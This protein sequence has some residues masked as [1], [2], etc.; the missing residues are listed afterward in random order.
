MDSVCGRFHLL[1]V[2]MVSH[3]SPPAP[4]M[5]SNCGEWV[6]IKT[7]SWA[8]SGR[9]KAGVRMHLILNKQNFS[10]TLNGSAQASPSRM[11]SS[12]LW[13]R[14]G[15]VPGGPTSGGAPA[16]PGPS[17][18]MWPSSFAGPHRQRGRWDLASAQVKERNA[19]SHLEKFELNF[20]KSFQH[21][22]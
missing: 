18:V 4:K 21:G 9:S 8:S 2:V 1:P 7:L 3:S 16:H 6:S 11:C 17:G 10:Y 20:L 22:Q 15:T 14:V 13:V 19:D 12:Q 5:W